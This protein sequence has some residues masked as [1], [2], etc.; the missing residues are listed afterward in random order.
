MQQERACG[1]ID[2]RL[3]SRASNL[4]VASRAHLLRGTEELRK[5]DTGGFRHLTKEASAIKMLKVSWSDRQQEMHKAALTIKEQKNWN[6]EQRK[7]DILDRLKAQ[8]GPFTCT[9]E[10]DEY[11]ISKKFSDNEKQ[12]RMRDEITYARDTSQSLPRAS[13]FFKIYD[14]TVTPR[15]LFTAEQF[16]NNL[17]LYLGKRSER[18][19]VS[20]DDFR[21]AVDK[22]LNK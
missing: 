5:K 8:N 17:K 14:T 11:L 13:P 6:V 2:N 20:L 18:L 15:R 22:C 7:L 9:E 1:D 12:K 19:K 3:K 4:N 21:L 16:G 10:V